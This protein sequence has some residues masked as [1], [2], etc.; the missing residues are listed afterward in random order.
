MKYYSQVSPFI[1]CFGVI[2]EVQSIIS[3]AGSMV[4]SK[5]T[6]CWGA[7]SL[8]LDVKMVRTVLA[9]WLSR[10]RY[11]LR[12]PL[13]WVLS[14]GDPQ[15]RRK[16]LVPVGGPPICAHTQVHV[17]IM[18]FVLQV[19]VQPRMNCLMHGYYISRMGSQ[20]HHAALGACGR[21]FSAS[22]Q[23]PQLCCQSPDTVHLLFSVPLESDG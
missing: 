18:S 1:W 16:G 21:L 19:I 4:A 14:W 11:L 2:S 8:R 12:R 15:G 20:K 3:M 9:L 7:K 23:S 6:W 10:Q 5:Q 13:I 17:G 22:E